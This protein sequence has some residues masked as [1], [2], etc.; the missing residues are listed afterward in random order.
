MV[1]K[2]YEDINI[3]IKKHNII[4]QANIAEYKYYEEM[5][6]KHVARHLTTLRLDGLPPSQ[7]PHVPTEIVMGKLEI[8]QKAIHLESQIIKKLKRQKKS[9]KKMFLSL[10]GLHYI[11][12]QMI[13]IEH[14]PYKEIACRLGYSYDYIKHLAIEIK[15]KFDID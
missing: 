13:I 1:I 4:L 12:A 3:E 5:L 15:S 7:F 8:L 10:N 2:N 11:I 9:Y 6:E 14:I